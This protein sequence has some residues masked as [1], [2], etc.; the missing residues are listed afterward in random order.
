ML[1]GISP[2]FALLSLILYIVLAFKDINPI[3]NVLLCVIITA[4][5]TNKPLLGMG[6]VIA[7]SLGSFLSLIGFII[8]IGSALGAILKKTG[9]AENIVRT[10]MKKIGINT[11]KKAVLSSM[12]TSMVLTALLGTLAGA[13][14]IIAP[15]I[16]PL[17]AAIGIT[18]SSLA[19][20]FMGA[21]LTG[22]F[23]GPFSPQVVTIMGLTGL[24]YGQYLIS[25]GLPVTAVCLIVTYIMANKI[26]KDTKGIYA[27]ENVENIDVNQEASVEAKRATYAFLITLVLLIIYGI[28]VKSGASYA[29]VVMFTAAIVTGV[30]AKLSLN[31][32]FD[33]LIQGASRMM[34]LF[35]MFVLFNPF[36]TFIEESGAF[37]ALVDL[38]EPLLASGNKIVFSLVSTLTGIFGIGGAAVA[39]SV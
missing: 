5:L 20:V 36:I 10:V 14:A 9:V 30:V 23:I 17:V 11:E 15:I 33:T 24:S 8:M 32:I 3:L 21:G 19:A 22:L 4:I 7:D 29:V 31:D 2:L 37:K 28:Y 27:Y 6:S 34:W 38:L 13:N 26:Q 39:Q 35:I 16:I 18:P 25:A 1:F 12:V